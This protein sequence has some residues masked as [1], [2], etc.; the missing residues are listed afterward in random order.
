MEG[1]RKKREK[2]DREGKGE[3]GRG[4]EV[5]LEFVAVLIICS[6]EGVFMV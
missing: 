3:K 2:R 1:R 6:D 4:E 5:F